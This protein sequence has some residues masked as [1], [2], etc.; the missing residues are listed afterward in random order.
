[1][2]QNPEDLQEA[3]AL[4]KFFSKKEHYESFRDGI[5]FFRTPHYYRNIEDI[6]RGDR[7]ESCIGFWDKELGDSVP[8]IKTNGSILTPTKMLIYPAREPRDSWLQSWSI[9]GPHNQFENSL[10]KMIKEFGN[11]FV[12]L[13]AGKIDRYATLITE[14]SNHPVSHGAV[15]Y[16][17]DPLERSLSVKD[18]S[19]TYQREYRFFLGE[20]SKSETRDKQVHINGI[21]DILEDALT[22]Q[23]V[24]PSGETKW[25]ELGNPEVTTKP[26]P[27]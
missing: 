6:G 15:R 9:I 26:A 1:M 19:N 11:Y 24:S 16:S 22:L 14:K 18:L 27:K 8:S 3:N 4:I 5:S 7:N 17:D 20:C 12:L 21:Q 2:N 10:A 13:P 25:C 23:F